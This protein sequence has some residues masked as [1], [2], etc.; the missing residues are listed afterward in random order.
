LVGLKVPD[1]APLDGQIGHGVR[2]VASLLD[3]VLAEPAISGRPGCPYGRR[4]EG[5]RHRQQ[6]HT[7]RIASGPAACRR[8]ARLRRL[9]I[10]GNTLLDYIEGHKNISCRSLRKRQPSAVGAIRVGSGSSSPLSAAL[11]S[12]FAIL[13]KPRPVRS[14]K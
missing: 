3:L 8:D 1:D 12:V 9:Q 2:L 10:L 13:G 11:A 6:A 5:F 4:S 7:G 14:L